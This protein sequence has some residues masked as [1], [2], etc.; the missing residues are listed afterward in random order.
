MVSNDLQEKQNVKNLITSTNLCLP[1]HSDYSHDWVTGS[2]MIP[3]LLSLNNG[4]C[5]LNCPL[6]YVRQRISSAKL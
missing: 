3:L 4:P 5:F 1:C 6:S 2:L